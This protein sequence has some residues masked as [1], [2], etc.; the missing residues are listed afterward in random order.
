[1]GLTFFTSL[2]DKGLVKQTIS[3]HVSC[4]EEK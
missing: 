3:A 4:R 1:M 2:Y